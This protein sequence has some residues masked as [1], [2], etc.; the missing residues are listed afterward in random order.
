MLIDVETTRK[1]L[2]A[3]L[4][5]EE[6]N[7][8]ISIS[9]ERKENFKAACDFE[10][11]NKFAVVLEDLLGQ[12]N[13]VYFQTD[14]K[15][16]IEIEGFNDRAVT[17]MNCEAKTWQTFKDGCNKSHLKISDVI[18]SIMGDYVAQVEKLNKIKISNGKIKK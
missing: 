14:K 11:F 1:N 18:E 5:R 7:A 3:L 9:K 17:S 16:K 2:K 6:V 10:G 13:E 8:S 12:L 4:E 15:L